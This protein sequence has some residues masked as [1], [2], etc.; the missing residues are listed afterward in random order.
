MTVT[1]ASVSQFDLGQIA[2]CG[3]IVL[4]CMQLPL[5]V[6]FLLENVDIVG[7]TPIPNAPDSFTISHIIQY[8]VNMVQQVS[9]SMIATHCHPQDM[10]VETRIIP[11]I[12]DLQAIRKFAGFKSHSATICWY[13]LCTISEKERLDWTMW[14]YRDGNTVWNQADKWHKEKWISEKE[15]LANQTAIRWTPMYDLQYW[16]PV[17]HI[18]FVLFGVLVIKFLRLRMKMTQRKDSQMQIFQ[19][20]KVNWVV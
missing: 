11:V 4:Y 12:A 10:P 8:I 6:W 1:D 2:S 9:G 3:P 16:D 5:E 13:C 17:M 20:L 15:A 7:T 19:N 14:L 18:N